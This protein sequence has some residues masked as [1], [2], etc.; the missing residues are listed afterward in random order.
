MRLERQRET[1]LSEESGLYPKGTG[2]LL[3]GLKQEQETV[4]C[5]F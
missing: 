5:T 1:S 2:E 3:Q 4:D